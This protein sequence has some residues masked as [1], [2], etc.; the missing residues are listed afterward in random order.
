[1]GPYPRLVAR[2]LY[3]RPGQRQLKAEVLAERAAMASLNGLE[4]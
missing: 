1:M 2:H 3:V 4:N